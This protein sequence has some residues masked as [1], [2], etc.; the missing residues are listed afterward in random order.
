MQLKTIKTQFPIFKHQPRLVY[1]DNAATSQK[2]AMV[3]NRIKDFYEKENAAVHRGIY[4][5]SENATAEF[6][7]V[8]DKVA[9]FIGAET[10]KEI[11]F[12]SGTTESINLVASGWGRKNIG[13]E[14][15]IVVTEMEHHANFVPWQELN[16]NLKFIPVDDNGQLQ[17]DQLAKLLTKKTKLVALTYISNVLG[18]INPVREIINQIKRINP[19]CLVLVDGA[20]AVPH[21][22]VNVQELGCDFLAFSAHKMLGPTGV[23]VL[24]GRAEILEAMEPV[25]FGGGMISRVERG[26]A[27]WASVPAK[28]EGGTPN[29]AGVIGLG[30]AIDFLNNVGLANIC[31]QEAQLTAY[32][33]E[34]LQAIDGI[35]IYGSQ[36]LES[37]GCKCGRCQICKLECGRELK[38]C[39]NRLGIISFNI[40]GIHAHDVAQVLG[41]AGIAVRAGHHCAMPLHQQLGVPASV[42]M[43]MY[44][45]NSREDVDL[46]AEGIGKVQK[47]LKNNQ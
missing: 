42:R 13:P 31:Q 22:P 30:A 45:Y 5:L 46:L 7:A 9:R 1:L 20:Q 2:P 36:E 33:L 8:R 44:L 18:T 16:S 15:E 3:I 37:C 47:V 27:I 6:E 24:W 43:S 21:L 41:D 35:V 4:P 40:K 32:A 29:I 12:T 23:G 17:L 26:R 28:F 39:K 11:I 14:D 38:L 19:K 34:K 10:S 25:K